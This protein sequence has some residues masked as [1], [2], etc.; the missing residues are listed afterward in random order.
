ME[1]L[2]A[3]L[4][5]YTLNRGWLNRLADMITR[6]QLSKEV[7]AIN[8]DVVFSS[9]SKLVIY[10]TLAVKMAKVAKKLAMIGGLGFAFTEQVKVFSKKKLKQK[11]LF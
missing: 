7:K 3:I 5:T 10:G 9:F 1:K 11:S 4:I 2:V 6:Y 8:L